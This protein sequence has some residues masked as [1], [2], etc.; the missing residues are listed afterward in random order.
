ME[1]VRIPLELHARLNVHSG[2]GIPFRGADR[3][4]CSEETDIRG[5]D[6][7]VVLAKAVLGTIALIDRPSRQSTLRLEGRPN[8]SYPT[9]NYFDRFRANLAT[10]LLHETI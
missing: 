5:Q 6:A 8:R 10:N 3:S 1:V 7:R 2:R 9:L 4:A